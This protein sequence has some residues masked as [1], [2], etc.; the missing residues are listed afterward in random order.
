MAKKF[1]RVAALEFDAASVE[2]GIFHLSFASE[3]PVLRKDKNGK[4]WEVLS[5]DPGDANLGQLNRQGIVLQD[6]DDTKEIGD[7]VRN[8]AKVDADKKTRADINIFDTPWLTRAKTEPSKIS[9]SVGYVQLSVISETKGEDGIPI[10]RFAWRPYEISLLTVQPADAGVGLN[11]AKRKCETC[12][13]N[14][15][16]RCRKSEDDDANDDCEDCGGDGDC[17]DCDGDGYF[18]SARSSDEDFEKYSFKNARTVDLN[19]ISE[20]QFQI[21]QTK[22]MAKEIEVIDETKVRAEAT[23]AAKTATEASERVRSKSIA[24][25]A[26][27]FIKK[28]G[29]KD[30]GKCGDKIREMANASIESGEDAKDFN[31]RAMQ[32][33]LNAEPEK[34]L[35]RDF[36]PEDDMAQFSVMRAIQQAARNKLAGRAPVPDEKELEG[37]VVSNYAKRCSEAEGGR[38]FVPQGFVLPPDVQFGSVALSRKDSLSAFRKAQNRYGRDMQANIFGQG[39]AL[40]PTYWLMPYIELLRNKSVLNRVGIRSMGGLTGNVVIPRLTA[41]STAYSVAEI[42]ALT[43][44]TPTVDQIPMTPHRIGALVNYSK[45]LIFQDSYGAESLV[46]DDM[47]EVLAL[48]K[49]LLGLNGQGGNSEPLGIM[50]TPGIGSVTFGAT[51]TY[52]KMVLFETLIRELNVTGKLAYASTS[53]TKGSLKTVAEAL[54]GA[55]TIGGAMN[56]IWKSIGGTGEEDGVVNGCQAVDSQQIPNNQVLAGA[57]D[58]FIEGI[59]GGFDVVVDIFTLKANAEISVAMNLWIDYVARHPQAFCVSTDAGNQ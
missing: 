54:T 19:T 59:F 17:S 34:V 51:P 50:N 12:D 53:A 35:A 26:D 39:G 43:A 28:H 29:G 11:R 8:S 46:R 10:R 14:G 6:H 18:S 20:K 13:G 55:T 27:E 15:R 30:A 33:V 41:P 22:F 16:C 38:G 48:K 9:V 4:Y 44:S 21:L 31:T 42:A 23:A 2:K 40:V 24:T 57:W 47:T 37:E 1:F 36:V 52:I 45:Q 56:A 58:Q 49:D 32:H 5:H 3:L 7:V 25:A